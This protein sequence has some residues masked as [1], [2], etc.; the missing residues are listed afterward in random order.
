MTNVDCEDVLGFALIGFMCWLVAQV[1][2]K[3]PEEANLEQN[4]EGAE[5]T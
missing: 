3:G 4:V 5:D 1:I 2:I